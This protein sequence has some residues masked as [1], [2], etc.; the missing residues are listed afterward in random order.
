MGGGGSQCLAFVMGGG[1]PVL[2]ICLQS[3]ACELATS[4]SV[5]FEGFILHMKTVKPCIDQY[6]GFQKG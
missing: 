5:I 4:V 2:G 3:E 1:V 6:S